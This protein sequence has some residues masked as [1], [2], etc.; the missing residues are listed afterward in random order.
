MQWQQRQQGTKTKQIP[1]AEFSIE[2]PEISG[3]LVGNVDQSTA[4]N[5]QC[6]PKCHTKRAM[7]TKVQQ[8]MSNVGPSTIQNQQCGPKY[9]TKGPP[10]K[11]PNPCSP[12]A[13]HRTS[14][15]MSLDAHMLSHHTPFPP[16]PP[17]IQAKVQHL[18]TS[19]VLMKPI[20]PLITIFIKR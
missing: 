11:N 8:K 18:M 20:W 4:Q 19:A 1:F 15:R 10:P 17:I 13:Q 12:C 7:W 14:L 6:G 5:D 3:N 16:P 2:W 9:S